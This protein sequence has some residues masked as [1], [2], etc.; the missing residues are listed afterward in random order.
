MDKVEMES[1][2]LATLDESFETD[3]ARFVQVFV[4]EVCAVESCLSCVVFSP[5][6]VLISSRA[7]NDS[8]ASAR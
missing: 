7:L 3:D 6:T 1:F 4:S 2:I 5:N 8:F